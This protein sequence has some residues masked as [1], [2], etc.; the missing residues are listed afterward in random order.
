MVGRIL[1]LQK[2]WSAALS[3]NSVS[4]EVETLFICIQHRIMCP[5][6]GIKVAHTLAMQ[7]KSIIL[8]S[9]FYLDAS[10]SWSV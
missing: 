4:K 3:W 7:L 9:N 6:V 10:S 5:C 8:F 1:C 2:F